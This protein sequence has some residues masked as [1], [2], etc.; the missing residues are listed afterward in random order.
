MS[1]LLASTLLLSE[2]LS[3]G[4]MQIPPRWFSGSALSH[5]LE[6]KYKDRW[7]ALDPVAGSQTKRC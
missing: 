2:M 6:A 5:V 1:I 3:A 4:I 7:L